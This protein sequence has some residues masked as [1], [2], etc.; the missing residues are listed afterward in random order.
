MKDIPNHFRDL[1]LIFLFIII[2]IF[3][4]DSR[5]FDGLGHRIEERY[6]GSIDSVIA[7]FYL[8]VFGYTWRSADHQRIFHFEAEAYQTNFIRR[9]RLCITRELTDWAYPT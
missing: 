7:L 8:N 1:K 5:C 3:Q 9:K 6:L 2:F 4:Y